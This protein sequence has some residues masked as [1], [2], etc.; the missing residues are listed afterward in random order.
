M[1]TTTPTNHQF[2]IGIE[3][4]TRGEAEAKF[5]TLL[6]LAA[7]L[8]DRDWK[9]LGLVALYQWATGKG[10][11]ALEKLYTPP[12]PT[13]AQIDALL[14]RGRQRRATKNTKDQKESIR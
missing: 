5:K 9:T 4:R 14:E 2:T 10:Y 12:S 11:E 13:D 6:Q 1:I 7:F 3:G 8:K